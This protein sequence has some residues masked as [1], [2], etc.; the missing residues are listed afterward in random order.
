MPITLFGAFMNKAQILTE[1]KRTASV[2]RQEYELSLPLPEKAV[3]VHVIKTDDPGGIEVYWHS[4]FALKRKN[5][6]W[7]DLECS[8]VSAFKRRKFM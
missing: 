6:E 1:I 3:M 5:G 4:R 2:G 8:D 7:F